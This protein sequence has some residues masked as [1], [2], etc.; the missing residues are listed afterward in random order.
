MAFANWIS[1]F[2]GL[3]LNNQL[4]ILIGEWKKTIEILEQ[5]VKYIQS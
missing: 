4:K 3:S 5:G 2:N 1:L